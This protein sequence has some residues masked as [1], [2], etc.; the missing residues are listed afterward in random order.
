MFRENN[1]C[2]YR[3]DN[4]DTNHDL[5]AARLPK[6]NILLKEKRDR[7]AVILRAIKVID[8]HPDP[9]SKRRMS[10][11]RERDRLQ[12]EINMITQQDV[13]HK[14]LHKRR[15][16]SSGKILSYCEKAIA[17]SV[18]AGISFI[19]AE[20]IARQLDTHVYLVKQCFMDLNHKGILSQPV[21]GHLHD[22]F[23]PEDSGWTADVYY[24][25]KTAEP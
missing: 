19:T 22:C 9:D 25:N 14:T 6:K 5:S 15:K 2:Y 12:H 7:L 20:D 13:T 10:L 17:D 4:K 24:I 23:R 8:A 11:V 21:H 18:N 16:L 1:F 3:L